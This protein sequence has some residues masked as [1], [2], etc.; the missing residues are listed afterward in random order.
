[1]TVSA[2]SDSRASCS[3][4]SRTPREPIPP[5]SALDRL[6]ALRP[7]LSCEFTAVVRFLS[8]VFTAV[9]PVLP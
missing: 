6:K 8:C 9:V 2:I 3:L 4:P 5:T 1:M 7:F